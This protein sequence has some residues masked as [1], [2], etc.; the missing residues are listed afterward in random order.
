M[1][2]PAPT[3]ALPLLFA[4]LCTGCGP[5]VAGAVLATSKGGGGG[6][7]GAPSTTGSSPSAPT[8][9]SITLDVQ[10][11]P[12]AGGTRVTATI[13]TPGRALTSAPSVQVGGARASGVTLLGPTSFSFDTPPSPDGNRSGAQP[14]KVST[15][16]ASATSSFR[17]VAAPP[18]VAGAS[19][20]VLDVDG[21]EAVTVTGTGFV[22]GTT[23][24]VGGAPATG[25][26]VTGATQ[27]TCVTPAG[28]PGPADLVV[29]HPD[30]G[31]ATLVGGV[32]FVAHLRIASAPAQVLVGQPFSITVEAVSGAGALVPSFTSSASVA[33]LSGPGGAA[34]T[35]TLSRAASGGVVTFAG[36][37]LDT[38]GSYTLSLTS[39]D[40]T[41]TTHDVEALTPRLAFLVEPATGAPGAP[42]EPAVVVALV[43]GAGAVAA[44]D[45]PITLDL[46]QGPAGA[47]L[48][49]AR[50]VTATAG[51]ARFFDLS[52]DLAGDGFT[53][54]ATSPGLT[55]VTTAPFSVAD[56][57]VTALSAPATAAVR[58][59]VT[60]A[61]TVAPA[62]ATTSLDGVDVTGVASVTTAPFPGPRGGV[63]PRR[64]L[65]LSATSPAGVG[66]R[67]E[68]AAAAR[69]RSP[70]RA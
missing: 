9:F 24:L 65:R 11:G 53:L 14:V 50:T 54:Q 1:R 15:G 46:D 7:G 25:V 67:V 10:T 57:R 62:S 32:R 19:P 39:A 70:P 31:A 16:G 60:V 63:D 12:A 6:G 13:T 58:E 20:A 42:I 66:E 43:D 45:A 29:V 34:L 5:L 22:A 33:V 26:V 56:V 44:I 64:A 17:Y 38:A 69:R 41:A 61:W 3:F 68:V 28:A 23:V 40:A 27:L 2:R 30:A 8:T 21:G 18:T 4:A 47:T 35:G 37:A 52:L 51:V 48:S 36:L 55:P 59:A 49:G